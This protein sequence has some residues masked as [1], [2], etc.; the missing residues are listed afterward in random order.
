MPDIEDVMSTSTSAATRTW[1]RAGDTGNAHVAA[2]VATPDEGNKT[3][4]ST[5]D[6]RHVPQTAWRIEG[7]WSIILARG[8]KAGFDVNY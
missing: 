6:V 4:E 8:A 1:T 2:D 5:A 3:E 7:A